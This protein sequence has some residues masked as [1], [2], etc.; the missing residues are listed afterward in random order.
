MFFPEKYGYNIMEEVSCEPIATCDRNMKT[1][2]GFLSW[3]LVYTAQLV[4][5]SIDQILPKLRASAEAAAKTCSGGNSGNGCSV[6]WVLQKFSGTTGMEEDMAALGVFSA[7]LFTF[8]DNKVPLSSSTG[9]TSKS[10]PSAGTSD[11]SSSFRPEVIRP[12]TTA[13]RASGGILTALLVSTILATIFF[14]IRD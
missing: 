1:Y 3:W 7:N 13:D 12:I 8:I 14:M 6:E 10:D 11:T 4:P 5:H 2:K 9:G